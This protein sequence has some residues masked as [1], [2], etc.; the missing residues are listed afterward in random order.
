MSLMAWELDDRDKVVIRFVLFCKRE[1]IF[2]TI[3]WISGTQNQV[4][5]RGF[6]WKFL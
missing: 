5:D 2:E 4:P 6:P 3:F 1:I